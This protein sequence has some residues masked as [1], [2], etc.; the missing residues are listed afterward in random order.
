MP[1]DSASPCWSAD[2]AKWVGELF[3]RAEREAGVTLSGQRDTGVALEVII[4]GR[5]WMPQP[6]VWL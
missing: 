6:G 4:G 3:G 5:G 1:F 2:A